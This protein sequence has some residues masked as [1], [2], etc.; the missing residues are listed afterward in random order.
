MCDINALV[1]T[2]DFVARIMF[3]AKLFWNQLEGTV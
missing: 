1:A 3:T 2:G